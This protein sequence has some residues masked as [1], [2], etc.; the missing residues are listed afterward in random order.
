MNP[1]DT[2][3]VLLAKVRSKY[4]PC[5]YQRFDN[6]T[7][8]PMRCGRGSIGKVQV[9]CRFMFTQSRWGVIGRS[10]NP[11]GIIFLDLDFHQPADCKLESATV[12]VT[13]A[14]NE[15]SVA[16]KDSR[17]S[18]CPIR[19]T[20]YYGPRSI[21]G[22]ES[23]V[24][25]KKVKNGTPEV[26]LFGYGL[27]GFGLNKEKAIL[28]KNRW[29][30]SGHI[31]GTNGCAWYNS[32]RWELKENSLEWQPT[33]SNVFHTAFAMEHNAEKF[34]MTV[35]VSGKLARLS[36]RVK[37]RLRYG[38]KG[39]RDEEIIT[40][41]EWAEGYSCLTQLDPLAKNLHEM[42]G[43]K[44]MEGVPVEM[45]SAYP[46]RSLS[47]VTLLNSAVDTQVGGE[48]ISDNATCN[49]DED[50]EDEEVEPEA[51]PEAEPK[52]RAKDI[53]LG[54]TAVLLRWFGMAG[55][56]LW[57]LA[58][59]VGL[60]LFSTINVNFTLLGLDS[61]PHERLAQDQNDQG[62]GMAD[63]LYDLLSE[64]GSSPSRSKADPSSLEYLTT[65]AAQ[66]LG[67]LAS[68]EPQTLAQSSHG[69][70]LSLQALSKKS[71]KQI[72]ESASHHATLR[73][74][75]PALAASTAELRNAIPKLDSEAVRFSTNYNK[76]SDSDVL[77]RRKK[78]L[79]LSRNVERL[80]DVL[81]L[82]TLLS[83]AISTAPVNYS[84]ALDLNGHIRRL[85][86]IYP[87]S[88]LVSSISTHADEAMRTM[89]ANLI[90]SLKTPGLKLAASLRTISWLR[91]VLPDLEAAALS[92]STTTTTTTPSN[93]K[94]HDSQERVLG[95]LFLVCRLATLMTMLEALEPLRELADQEKTRQQKALGNAR[96]GGGQQT[97]RYLKRYIEIFREQSF[98]I[99]SM[100]RS[101]FP[102]AT[103]LPS[104]GPAPVAM[105]GD[106]LEPMPAAL[107][108]FPLYLVD[109]LLE[110][111]RVY[112]PTVKDQAARDSLLTQVLYCA[113]SL[114]RL[115]G[116]FGL[117]LATLDVGPEAEE[118]W[119][120]IV[121]RHR[122]LAG[123][124]ESIVGEQRR[125]S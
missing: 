16:P 17:Q 115:G 42:M 90:L 36:E 15:N 73:T 93:N 32:L 112:F 21:R 29:D 113:G 109:M 94:G 25:T 4:A 117:F 65:L 61:W 28:T 3:P 79:L 26:Q 66:P 107:A 114:G 55:M 69:L 19:F 6:M 39:S 71:H 33:H 75:L 95:A 102:S 46:A 58:N 89:A 5:D 8:T 41:F 108:T 10:R 104:D 101:I 87:K 47:S 96:P 78:A 77:A 37:H 91:R 88:P 68:T 122:A 59:V 123:R 70:L 38:G 50:L 44:N 22:E 12:I 52:V 18:L 2:N 9:D 67:S 27:G 7:S 125:G 49:L 31:D 106:L 56:L 1:Q 40:K 35:Q 124:L 100:F 110:T 119:V 54:V 85:H 23:V 99:V 30:F 83:S 86:S 43:L 98:A 105:G 62:A 81:E 72:I 121:K 118:E 120:E 92:S 45:P 60:P 51:V 74:T 97:E 14:D 11:G 84:S 53:W 24:Q 64:P 116:D 82:P 34:Y 20:D 111:L 48:N 63:L 57:E 103:T 76:S 13:L 80:V